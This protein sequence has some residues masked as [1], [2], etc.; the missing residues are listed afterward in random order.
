MLSLLYNLII[1]VTIKMYRQMRAEEKTGRRRCQQLERNYSET[2]LSPNI[3]HLLCISA[4]KE[5]A[6]YPGKRWLSGN[7]LIDWDLPL[8][9]LYP[10]LHSDNFNR[11]ILQLHNIY[12]SLCGLFQL[13][14]L[15]IL[16]ISLSVQRFLLQCWLRLKPITVFAQG[17]ISSRDMDIT[18]NGPHQKR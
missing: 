2:T 9:G 6:K 14:D 5:S 4:L 11:F 16:T 18:L 12:V 17:M 1:L 3:H 8:P 15:L 7:G 10:C 13:R